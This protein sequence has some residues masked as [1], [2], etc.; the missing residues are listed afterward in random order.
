[1]TKNGIAKAT[2]AACAASLM[3]VGPAFAA[4]P[5]R[6]ITVIVPYGPGG[7][8]DI[9]TRTWAPYMEEC[10]GNGAKIVVI[11]RPGAG[12]QIGWTELAHTIPDGYTLGALTSPTL[13]LSTITFEPQYSVESFDFL[14]SFTASSITINVARDGKYDSLDAL[15]EAA[16]AANGTLNMA[17][18]QLGGDDHLLLKRLED[19]LS[20]K[21]NF[22]PMG[23]EAATRSA[24]LGGNVD[25]A[26]FSAGAVAQ[27]Q[28]QL[29]SLAVAADER[30]SLLPDTPTLKELGHDLVGG[31]NH[32]IGAPHGLPTD[33]YDK[34]A[35]CVETIAQN[36]D[37][38]A[39]ITSRNMML[40]PMNAATLTEYVTNLHK[41]Y[42][43]MWATS[44]WVDK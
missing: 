44:P 10:L 27:F 12:G 6:A 40:A 20:V 15:I 13:E 42:T 18:G 7:A 1:M 36:P 39:D 5:E 21:F 26:G 17:V 41:V 31:S 32:L 35:A 37:Y 16:K 28:D 24:L 2:L 8:N 23:D 30:T 33:V 11:N 43:E 25:A 9:G 19:L 38:R 4:Y 22:I 3:A 34:I 29:L 14:G